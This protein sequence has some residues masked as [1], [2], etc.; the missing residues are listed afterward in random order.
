MAPLRTT[1]GRPLSLFLSFV[2]SFFLLTKPALRQRQHL[3]CT[4]DGR[5]FPVHSPHSPC[6]EA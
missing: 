4:A 1:V 5:N 2:K 6:T 3:S